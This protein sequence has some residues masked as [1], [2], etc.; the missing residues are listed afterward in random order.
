L[1]NSLG[2]TL[3]LPKVPAFLIRLGMGE[4]ANIVLTGRRVSSD[5]IKSLGFRFQFKNL[6]S[7][8]KDCL[9]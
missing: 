7:A 1:A 2:Y 5:K 4:M 3:W 6:K 8:L 9:K